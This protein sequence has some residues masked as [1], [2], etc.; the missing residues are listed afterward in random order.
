LVLGITPIGYRTSV[1]TVASVAMEEVS[2]G[3]RDYSQKTATSGLGCSASPME[4]SLAGVEGEADVLDEL[5]RTGWGATIDAD[6]E[7]PP[8]RREGVHPAVI[9]YPAKINP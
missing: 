1:G 8:L 7:Q 6:I 9:L 5:W 2:G 4:A 3:T